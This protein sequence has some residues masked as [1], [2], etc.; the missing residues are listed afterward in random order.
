MA[1][2][3]ATA[4]IENAVAR[5]PRP[6]AAAV[7]HAVMWAAMLPCLLGVPPVWRLASLFALTLLA[8][9]AAVRVRRTG[10]G[11]GML[12]DALA[13]AVLSVA[14]EL[15]HG[16]APA[17]HAA[18]GGGSVATALAVATAVAWAALRVS[19]ARS[20]HAGAAFPRVAAA[21]A[22]TAMVAVMVGTIVLGP[23]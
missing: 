2:L 22:P 17:E 4:L 15:P 5:P 11:P 7:P 6:L 21:L 16:A 23:H 19:G 10:A 12:L 1:T 18:H 13:M 3:G 14:A 9:W 8:G 20:P